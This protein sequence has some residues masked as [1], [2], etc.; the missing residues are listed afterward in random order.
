M[1]DIWKKTLG[2]INGI[3]IF[4]KNLMNGSPL[5]RK[6]TKDKALIYGGIGVISAAIIARF[7]I[8]LV[9]F[10][11]GIISIIWKNEIKKFASDLR[12]LLPLYLSSSGRINRRTFW[13]TIFILNLLI[14][15]FGLVVFLLTFIIAIIPFLNFLA[16]PIW[17]IG[18]ILVVPTGVWAL[19]ATC[20]KRC[21]DIGLNPHL[22]WLMLIPTGVTNLIGTILLGC[23]PSNMIERSYDDLASYAAKGDPEAQYELGLRFQNGYGVL[24]SHSEAIKWYNESANNGY[25]HAAFHLAGIYEKGEVVAGN[26]VEA[27]RLY[28]LDANQGHAEAQ[29][30]LGVIFK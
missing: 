14:L 15:F 12:H 11:A 4:F 1:E 30:I 28:E 29:G 7:P 18:F 22:L 26:A 8:T 16:G 5:L 13:H 3:G 6:G 20:I 27:V 9:L 25:V 24:Q 23:L 10:A 17:V 21:K 2:S 19:A